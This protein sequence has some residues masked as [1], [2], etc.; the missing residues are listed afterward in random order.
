MLIGEQG[1]VER[2]M[3]MDGWKKCW[4]LLKLSKDCNA[5]I[6][7]AERYRQDDESGENMES[8]EDV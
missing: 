3:I 1:Y 5:G 6:I 8:I 7:F 4:L 2:R